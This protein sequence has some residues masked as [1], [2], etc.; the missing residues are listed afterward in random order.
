[1][2]S[3]KKAFGGDKEVSSVTRLIEIYSSNEYEENSI[4]GLVI[5]ILSNE[6]LTNKDSVFDIVESI[7]FMKS[8]G[9]VEASRALRKQ[10]KHGSTHQNIRAL[11]IFHGCVSNGINNSNFPDSELEARFRLIA[12]DPVYDSKVKKKLRSV[13]R[14]I[15]EE[16]NQ[17]SRYKQLYEDCGSVKPARPARRTPSTLSKLSTSS[18]PK[19]NQQK[20]HKVAD[21]PIEIEDPFADPPDTR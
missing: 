4:E 12:S 3:L 13:L 8:N 15:C 5:S 16:N 14:S 21:S 11:T 20:A 18:I 19:L 10:L 6:S 9:A 7:H 2:K 17:N 1:M